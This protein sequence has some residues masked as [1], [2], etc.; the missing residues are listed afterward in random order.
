VGRFFTSSQRGLRRV[1]VAEHVLHALGHQHQVIGPQRQRL[2]ADLQPAAA[3]QHDV[4][5]RVHGVEKVHRPVAVEVLRVIDHALDAQRLE[6]GVEGGHRQRRNGLVSTGRG[7]GW[8]E[9]GAWTLRH[10]FWILCHSQSSRCFLAFGPSK[11]LPDCLHDHA[12]LH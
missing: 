12:A 4:D 2:T 8:R 6:Q 3:P 5:A 10:D 11:L 7:R 1:A 9:N